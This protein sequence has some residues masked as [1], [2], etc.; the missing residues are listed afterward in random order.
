MEKRWSEMGERV[1]M[2]LLVQLLSMEEGFSLFFSSSC[3]VTCAYQS[4]LNKP[5]LHPYA[6]HFLLEDGANYRA[7]IYTALGACLAPIYISWVPTLPEACRTLHCL[8]WRASQL[9][10]QRW[11][12]KNAQTGEAPW[13]YF[14]WQPGLIPL[15]L[16]GI[17][18]LFQSLPAV[19]HT[20]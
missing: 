18:I 16:G 7:C 15:M 17:W 13:I 4:L 20:Q 6:K 5:F 11:L 8:Q 10:K 14:P 3:W 9:Q 12:K 2:E 19:R 1:K